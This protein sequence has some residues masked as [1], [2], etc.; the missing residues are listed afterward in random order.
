V[1][2]SLSPDRLS[3]VI[4]H[5]I[6]PAFVLGA[7]ASFTGILSI[8]LNTIIERIRVLNALPKEGQ[9]ASFLRADLP[10]LKRRAELTNRAILYAVI[11]GAISAA[12][13]IV[14]FVCAFLGI[15]HV[16]GAGIMFVI[17]LLFL[18]AALIVFAFE[19]RIA[20]TD[21]DHHNPA[22]N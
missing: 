22:Q 3:Q 18:V 16:Y 9:D 7:V 17:A 20:L 15:E 14:A 5:A 2:E 4:A 8:R 12:L 6:A 21:Y 10:R 1:F 19:V 11:S 13:L